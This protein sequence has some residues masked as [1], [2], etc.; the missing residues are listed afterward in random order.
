MQGTCDEAAAGV[1]THRDPAAWVSPKWES[2]LRSSD[3]RTAQ[4][5][6]KPETRSFIGKYY[7]PHL[8]VGT[9]LLSHR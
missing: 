6:H 1:T 2:T 8:I 4:Q 3:G 5:L 9:T 7:S